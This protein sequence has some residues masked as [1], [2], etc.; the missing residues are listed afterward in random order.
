MVAALRGKS[1]KVL[2]VDLDNTVWGG[3]IGDDG[4]EG[5]KIAQGDATGEVHLA[6]QRMPLDLRRRGMAVSSKNTDGCA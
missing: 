4:L 5:I 3:I 1:G 2:V 6:A